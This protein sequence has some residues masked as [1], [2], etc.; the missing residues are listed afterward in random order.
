LGLRFTKQSLRFT[1]QA[2]TQIDIPCC[3]LWNIQI[4][5]FIKVHVQQRSERLSKNCC[6]IVQLKRKRQ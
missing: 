5:N 6:N 4:D 3:L 1:K 2:L